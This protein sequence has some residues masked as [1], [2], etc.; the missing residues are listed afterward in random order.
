[1]GCVYTSYP[2]SLI[3]L[4][5]HRFT[6]QLIEKSLGIRQT[7]VHSSIGKSIRKKT[8][9]NST[10]MHEKAIQIDGTTLEGGGQLLRLAV[11]LST[12]SNTP[13]QINNIR[14]KRRGDGGL[15]LQ[16]L[17]AVT[18][19]AEASGA[20]VRGAEKGSK[21]LIFLP[22]RK[23]PRDGSKPVLKTKIDIT[24]PGAVTL[25]IQAILPYL[26]FAGASHQ[27]ELGKD[28]EPQD[29]RL[30]LLGG[31]NVSNAPSIDHVQH[32]LIPTLNSM[33]GEERVSL[34]VKKRCWSASG[35]GGVYGGLGEVDLIVRPLKTA[36]SLPAFNLDTQGNLQK[37]VVYAQAPAGC[38]EKIE[39]EIH[40]EV[41]SPLFT[42]FIPETSSNDDEKPRIPV[43]IHFTPTSHNSH[44]AILFIAHFSPDL[45]G[46]RDSSKSIPVILAHDT[47]HLGH[48]PN[49]PSLTA[50]YLI[51]QASNTLSKEIASGACID[52]YMRDHIVA[53]QALATGRCNIY[54]GSN[55]LGEIKGPDD[56]EE[57]AAEE[58]AGNE[59]SE[60]VESNNATFET[61]DPTRRKG[62]LHSRT[63][64]WVTQKVLGT[65]FSPS[66]L[67]DGA[68]FVVGS[69]P[70]IVSA[71][72]VE[73]TSH[74]PEP[75][76][77]SSSKKKGKTGTGPGRAK[78]GK[79]AGSG[80]L[81]AD[82][83]ADLDI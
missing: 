19:L 27:K 76:S 28:E 1:M 11:C 59:R 10:K 4:S 51:R 56:G 65:P 64:W 2:A 35:R 29:I 5:K 34:D 77:D 21:N 70:Q 44:I 43:D 55:E 54:P 79:S 75:A 22:A 42:K 63:A 40:R 62:S 16:H 39:A 30:T 45:A 58:S 24:T 26:L 17:K 50:T 9:A 32:V 15:K 81:L 41:A 8:I 72:H 46:T 33:F 82:A 13:I 71:Q 20:E 38:E 3:A 69:G 14:G 12:L 52:A 31:T 47:L 67:C 68:S 57:E 7:F 6:Y 49:N 78:F 18:W 66:G 25:L 74:V 73:R 60:D 61:K 48:K 36:S 23:M 83:M 37:I 80:K 53:Y